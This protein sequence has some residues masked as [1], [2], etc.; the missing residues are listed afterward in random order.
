MQLE[1]S[2]VSGTEMQLERSEVPGTEMQL[3]NSIVSG[4]EVK[5]ENSNKVRHRNEVRKFYSV[6][7]SV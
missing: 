3:E 2:I 4:T 6:W 5:L 1:S 7:H